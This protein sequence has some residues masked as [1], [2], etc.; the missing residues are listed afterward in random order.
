ME[1]STVAGKL[2]KRDRVAR[3]P[4]QRDRV[5]RMPAERD[6]VARNLPSATD[7]LNPLEFRHIL[8]RLGADTERR[9]LVGAVLRA[10]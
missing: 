10:A 9:A 6:R 5:A 7:R 3:E 8:R 1:V 2:A 4:A